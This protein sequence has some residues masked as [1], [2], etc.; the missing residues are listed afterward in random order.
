MKH[1]DPTLIIRAQ[2]GDRAAFQQ[3]LAQ[4]YDMIYRV[5][6]RFTGHRQ[7]AEDVA[8]E[9]C[10]GLVRKLEIFRGDSSFS[11]WLYRVVVNSCRDYQKK[12]G[13]HRSLEQRYLEVEK[14]EQADHNETNKQIAWLYRHLSTM[15][16]SLKETAILV[17]TE[18]R[19]HA[20]AGK[21]LGCAESTISWRMHAVRQH[22]K[23]A[24]D[25]YYD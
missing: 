24:M 16:E 2:Q 7:D 9:V 20:E 21:I 5:A 19:S 15:E 25:S 6:Y 12:S 3:L 4:H 14:H 1:T 13:S 17:L 18:E 23:N 11:T 22:L 8:Q 10:I